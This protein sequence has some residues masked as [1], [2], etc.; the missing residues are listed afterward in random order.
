MLF[1]IILTFIP[2]FH[3]LRKKSEVATLRKLLQRF[4]RF[5]EEEFILQRFYFCLVKQSVSI[6]YGDYFMRDGHSL[7]VTRLKIV[8]KCSSTFFKVLVMVSENFIDNILSGS[9]ERFPPIGKLLCNTK[10]LLF[11]TLSAFLSRR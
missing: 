6:C 3:V 1:F 4:A 8:V 5:S 10:S 11:E 9:F 2:F 7:D